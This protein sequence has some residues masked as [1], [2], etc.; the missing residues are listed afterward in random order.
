MSLGN[1]KVFFPPKDSINLILWIAMWINTLVLGGRNSFSPS[2]FVH[3]M[4]W[5]YKH[6]CVL[7][8]TSLVVETIS[9]ALV[10]HTKRH[11]KCFEHASS[12]LLSEYPCNLSGSSRIRVYNDQKAKDPM[13]KR[14]VYFSNNISALNIS[15]AINSPFGQT[16]TVRFIPLHK[17]LTVTLLYYCVLSAKWGSRILSP[18]AYNL[19][20]VC[21]LMLYLFWNLGPQ[22]SSMNT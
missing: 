6:F 1:L 22:S 5:V 2:S 12:Q 14:P 20:C 16:K 19:R 15:S 21:I 9:F 10:C 4:L 17:M 3:M 18:I 13:E 11:S 7:K 8:T